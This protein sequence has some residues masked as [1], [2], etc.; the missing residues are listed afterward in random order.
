MEKTAAKAFALLE[1]MTAHDG[2]CGVSELARE[3]R[4]AKSNVHRLLGTLVSLGY[5][6]RHADGTYEATLKAWEIGVRVLNRLE[7]K[8]IA[9]PHLAKLARQ[10]DET[11][12]L[13]A[14]DE[15][16]IVYI[17]KIESSHPVREFTRVGDR[18]PAHCTATGKAM[19]AFGAGGGAPVPTPLRRFTMNTISNPGKLDG[20]LRRVRRAGFAFNFGEYGAHV[21]GVAAPIAD[22]SGAVVAALAI[23]GPAER[24][25][26]PVLKDFVPLVLR[27][28][29]AIS[30]DLGCR[31]SYPGWTPSPS[32][33]ETSP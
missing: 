24:L 11:V 33:P 13:S 5:A 29:H 32:S 7:I 18:A 21:N 20:E 19:L 27:T 10:T 25:R 22:N 31:K 28:A 2:S 8:K 26:P 15:G 9:R 16:Q 4:F 6:R 14:L 3:L 23:S 17:D 1:R 12:H 30:A